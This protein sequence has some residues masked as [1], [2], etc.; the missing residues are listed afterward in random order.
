MLPALV[1][2]ARLFYYLQV[3]CG[4]LLLVPDVLSAVFIVVLCYI[5]LYLFS[6]GGGG[7]QRVV[8]DSFVAR[9]SPDCLLVWGDSAN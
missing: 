3:V 5:I 9:V 6:G 4:K 2:E 1:I 7:S 8:G